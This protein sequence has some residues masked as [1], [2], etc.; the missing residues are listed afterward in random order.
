VV[1]I[2]APDNVTA[3]QVALT[4]LERICT[5]LERAI[6]YSKMSLMCQVNNVLLFFSQ[7]LIQNSSRSLKMLGFT[8]S[9]DQVHTFALNG[10][11]VAFQLGF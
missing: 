3:Q 9:C 10:N 5:S 4:P 2:I 8:L 11:G 6:L 7:R 1:S